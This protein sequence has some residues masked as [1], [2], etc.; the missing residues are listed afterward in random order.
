MSL[1]DIA[2]KAQAIG[3][4]RRLQILRRLAVGGAN[5]DELCAE[6]GGVALTTMRWHLDMLL[7]VGFVVASEGTPMVYFAVCPAVSS[8]IQEIEWLVR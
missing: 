8:F 3:H 6:L 7:E 2:A 4:V 1:S 5:S